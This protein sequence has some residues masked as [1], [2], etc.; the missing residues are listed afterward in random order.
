MKKNLMIICTTIFSA[1]CIS[2]FL[3]AKTNAQQSNSPDVVRK[4]IVNKIIP[5]IPGAKSEVSPPPWDYLNPR[6]KSDISRRA[7]AAKVTKKSAQ[8]SSETSKQVSTHNL[9]IP[10]QDIPP[11]NPA[12]KIDP[13]IVLIKETIVKNP[14]TSEPPFIDPVP[15]EPLQLID[16]SQLKLTAIVIRDNG[17]RGLVQESSGKGH[18]IAKNTLIGTR[19]GKV[20]EITKDRVIIE[21]RMRND[22][23]RIVTKKKEL[24]LPTF[25]TLNNRN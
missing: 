18:I 5:S 25:L 3:A 19:G 7:N 23:G 22:S 16:L 12:G 17:N 14:D 21:E 10:G 6:P 11:Y 24:S 13:F 20:I 8:S 9:S 1:C 2:L 4:K 15:K